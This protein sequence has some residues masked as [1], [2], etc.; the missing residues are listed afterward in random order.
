MNAFRT[1]IKRFSGGIV[2]RQV[3]TPRRALMYVPG[4]DKR[5]LRKASQLEAD[6]IA[7]DLEDGVAMNKK[8]VARQTVRAYFE[9]G[10]TEISPETRKSEWCVRVNSSRSG[11]C[12]DDLNVILGGTITPQ[13]ILL[14]K[15][16]SPEDFKFF[17]D[18]LDKLPT[19]KTPINLIFYAESC[20]AVLHL[21]Q[22]CETAS[23]LSKRSAKFV[24]VGIVFGSD[25]FC[26]SLGVS[27]SD[28]AKEVFYARQRIAL[29]AKAYELQAI[30]MVYIDYKNLDGLK[31]QSLEGARFGYTGKQVIH[32]GQLEIVQKAFIPDPELVDWAKELVTAWEQHQKD[33][34]GAFTFKNSMVD[35]PT[36][37]QAR[38]II[39][40]MRSAQ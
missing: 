21:P 29:V 34:V 35:A 2:Y 23:E 7:L 33:G 9:S 1:V 6:C 18:Q 25:D 8:E 5:K 22:L 3:H 38:N 28:E 17:S 24:P 16:D 31:R 26:A 32:P 12:E 15:A 4:D 27:R 36:M 11:L 37:K 13:T 14:P 10:V 39:E 40:V 20:K 30:D 19:P